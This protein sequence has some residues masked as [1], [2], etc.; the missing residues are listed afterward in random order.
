MAEGLKIDPAIERWASLRENTHLYFA[1]NKRNA[2]RSLFWG[3]AIPVGLT[4]LAYATDVM[5]QL[6]DY[7]YNITDVF[8]HH[9]VNGTLLLLKQNK[10]CLPR[11]SRF[12]IIIIKPI[13][14]VI[15]TRI[16]NLSIEH[17]N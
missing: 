4:V 8:I 2:R 10:I 7:Q 13:K 15:T 1:W 3:V 17:R 5:L 11:R 16:M 12:F 6:I 14:K 9:S